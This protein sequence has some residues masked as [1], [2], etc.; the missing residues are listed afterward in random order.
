MTR[1]ETVTIVYQH[2]KILLGMKKKRFGIG[3]YNGF[4]GKVEDGETLE[5]AAVR[6]TIE[7]AGITVVNPQKFG[8][9]LFKFQT[10]E[11]DHLVHFFK[12]TKYSGNL[13]ESDEMK[14]EWFH[15]DEIPYNQMW[16]DDKYWLPLLLSGKKF[17]GNFT[18]NKD[19]QVA[20]YSLKEVETF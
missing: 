9:I 6:E 11:Q 8:E 7:E 12:A 18:F 19:F 15:A 14:P 2:P 17:K 3:K 1:I 4:G 16:A 20:E 10:D 5:L 13:I